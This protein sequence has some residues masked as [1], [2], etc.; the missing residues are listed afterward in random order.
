MGVYSGLLHDLQ[1][2]NAW[3]W[4]SIS[5]SEHW[6]SRNVISPWV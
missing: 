3:A 4:A 1:S 5:Q 2:E 6:P